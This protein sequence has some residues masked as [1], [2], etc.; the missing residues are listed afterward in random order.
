MIPS[1]MVGALSMGSRQTGYSAA[2]Q[3]NNPRLNSH[4][5]IG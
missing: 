4:Q 3:Q 2:G 5:P 1:R